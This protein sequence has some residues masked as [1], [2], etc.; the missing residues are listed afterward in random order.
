MNPYRSLFTLFCFSTQHFI[1]MKTNNTRR[2]FLKKSVLGG[3]ALGTG[4]FATGTIGLGQ[5]T[6]TLKE[7]IRPR[8]GKSVMGFR[9]D[10]IPTVRIAVIGL[11]RGSGAVY[12]LARIE[13]AS[14]VAISDLLPDRIAATQK[15]LRDAGHSE[16]AAYSGEEDWKKIC[17]RDDIDLIY[18]ATP[19]DLHVPIALYAM[20]NGKHAAT[21]VPVA[22]TVEGCW[23][24]VD[25]A[26]QT[27]RHCMMLENCCYDFFEL[28]TLN[29]ARHDVFGEI[30]HGECAYIHE[31][32]GFHFSDR[33]FPKRWRLEYYKKHTGNLYPTHGLGPIAQIMG[34]NRGDRFDYLTS[35]ST[36]HYG[37]AQYTE[38]TFGK[39]SPEAKTTYQLGDMNT[40]MVRTVGGRT[41]LIQFDI[42]SP[43]PYDRIHKI[44]GTKGYAVKYP[45]ERIALDPE[46]NAFL[47]P[48]DMKA[49]ME[50]YKH[51]LTKY[52][53]EKARTVGGHGGMD[54]MMDWRLIYCLRNGL[55]LDQ[56]V[57]DAATWSCIVELSEQSV[58]NRSNTVDVPDF[59][60]GDWKNAKPWPVIDMVDVFC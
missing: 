12:R 33:D 28:D 11:S 31:A 54:F 17:E 50:K 56:D 15:H 24:L 19:W 58:L 38:R 47:K 20:K 57:Y 10:P 52:I 40:T 45:E 59:T 37:I 34:I 26:E 27:Q 4:G 29:M 8:Q 9:C 30:Y 3:F 18:S 2:D 41:I 6:E 46:P 14:V 53:G 36:N 5:N 44:S 42:T 16:A 22:L 23:A 43:R 13:G 35:M 1:Q 48:E 39:D 51:P 60:R 32:R 55:P 49:L 21:E 25:T 7:T